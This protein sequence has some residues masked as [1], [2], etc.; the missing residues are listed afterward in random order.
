MKKD[1]S[2]SLSGYL[3]GVDKIAR[4]GPEQGVLWGQVL[5]VCIITTSDKS[6]PNR[7]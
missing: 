5:Y 1:E 4:L 2:G 7:S 6:I 3:I